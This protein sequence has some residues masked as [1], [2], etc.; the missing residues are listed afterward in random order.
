MKD[1]V[2]TP[3]EEQKPAKKAP[4]PAPAPETVETPSEE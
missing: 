3:A 1:A 2:F 4:A